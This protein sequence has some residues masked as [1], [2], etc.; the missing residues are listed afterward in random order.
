MTWNAEHLQ[1][2]YNSWRNL[3][4]NVLIIVDGEKWTILDVSLMSG[5]SENYLALRLIDEHK[6]YHTIKFEAD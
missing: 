5:T 4:D 2:L 1:N 6:E 3:R